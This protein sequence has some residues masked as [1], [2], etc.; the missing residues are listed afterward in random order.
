M[1]T[2][3]LILWTLTV[4]GCSTTQEPEHLKDARA[5]LAAN[6]ALWLEQGIESYSMILQR[7]CFC[8]PEWRGP[9]EM[10]VRER[11]VVSWTYVESGASVPD[12]R[13]EFF[14]PVAGLFNEIEEAID[15]EAD[16]VI[17]EYHTELGYPLTVFIDENL[18]TADEEVGY[19]VEELVPES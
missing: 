1:R 11:D 15:R 18:Q 10:Q 8:P 12:D 14:P 19:E 6:R 9:I 5:H 7:N 17:A 2:I 13:V 4:L 3:P 16:D